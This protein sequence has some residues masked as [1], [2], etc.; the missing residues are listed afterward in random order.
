MHMG[1]PKLSRDFRELLWFLARHRARYL[2]IGGHAVMLY[3]EPRYTKDLDIWVDPGVANA[4]RVYRALGEY[5]APLEGL[6]PEDFTHD[7]FQIGVEPVR[8]DILTTLSGLRFDSAWK[9]RNTVTVEKRRVHFI[10]KRDL[11][12]L[13]RAAGRR[14]DL[15]DLDWLEGRA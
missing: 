14:R 6:T 3:T 2:I 7:G 13:K 10:S 1:L 9:R 12:R 15:E 4:Q 5:G 8:V 11:I